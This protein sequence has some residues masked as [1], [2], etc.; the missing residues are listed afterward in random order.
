MFPLMGLFFIL[1]LLGIFSGLVFLLIPRLRFLSSYAFFIPVFS[2]LAGFS[3]FW[4]GAFLHERMHV[5]SLLPF[6]RICINII[7]LGSVPLGML[8]AATAGFFLARRIN[9]LTA[10]NKA[11]EP[12]ASSSV[13]LDSPE[14][15]GSP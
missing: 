14:R 2:A 10:P 3:L 6:V 15:G 1:A 9:R 13:D 11:L 8:V 4:G 5:R 7:F 12:T